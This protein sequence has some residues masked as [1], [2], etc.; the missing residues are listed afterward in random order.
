[1]IC[2]MVQLQEKVQIIGDDL[3]VSN[4]N[5]IA[6]GIEKGL[7][8]G[9]IIKPNQIGTIT[10]TL[11]A[12]KLC[13]EYEMS[14]VISHRSC[15]TNDTMIVDLAVGT[16]AGYIKAGGIARGEHVGKYN[17]LLRIEDALMLSILNS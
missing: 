6:N 8:T 4:P 10:E 1:M 2:M 11:Q 17:E 14:C 3:F 12:I 13:R 7:A 15:E 16:S 5:L 9:V